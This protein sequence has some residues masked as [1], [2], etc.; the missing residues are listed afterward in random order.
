MRSSLRLHV[1][2]VVVTG[3]GT[4]DPSIVFTRVFVITTTKVSTLTLPINKLDKTAIA[5]NAALIT[6][7]PV[8]LVIGHV[9]V[10]VPTIHGPI[11]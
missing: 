8:T 1:T 9:T 4:V 2:I 6:T 5:R 10:E 3:G 11:K 7:V